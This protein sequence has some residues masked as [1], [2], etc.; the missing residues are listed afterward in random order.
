MNVFN[1]PGNGG[2]F[3]FGSV[4]G[5]ADLTASYSGSVLTLGP[6]TIGDP[7]PYWYIGGGGPGAPGNKI[8]EANAYAQEDGPLA[9]QTLTFSGIVLANTLTSA[10]TVI[11]FVKDFAP[12]FSSF[13]QNTVA[14]TTPGL[15]TVSLATVNDP[16]RHVQWGFQMVG[17]NVWVTDVGPFGTMT[18]GPDPVTPTGATSWGR[19]KTLYR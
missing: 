1:L 11:A 6:N 12:D 8:M 15:F 5:F 10:H 2:A 13:N 7:D 18:I 4:W 3:Q 16:A 9:G 14:L 17:V 19:L